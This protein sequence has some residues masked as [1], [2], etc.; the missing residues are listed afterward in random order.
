MVT[1]KAI[2]LYFENDSENVIWKLLNFVP[3]CHSYLYQER[4]I[5][6]IYLT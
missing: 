4:T 3:K 5:Y 2:Y 6:L 1:F